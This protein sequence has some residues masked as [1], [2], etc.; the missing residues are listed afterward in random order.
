MKFRFKALGK[1]KMFQV[2]NMSL[3]DMTDKILFGEKDAPLPSTIGDM[4]SE[5]AKEGFTEWPDDENEKLEML[6]KCR[7]VLDEKGSMTKLL[8]L[9]EEYDPEFCKKYRL[10]IDE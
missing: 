5:I 1:D 3:T 8:E 6:D 10:L 7:I 9:V 4:V 2:I